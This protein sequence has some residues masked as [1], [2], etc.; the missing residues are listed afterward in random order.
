MSAAQIESL[1]S[2]VAVARGLGADAAA[3]LTGTTLGQ[4]EASADALASVLDEHGVRHEQESTAGPGLFTEIAAAQ[5]RRKQALAE[6]LCGRAPQPRDELGR[7]AKSGTSFDGGARRSVPIAKSPEQAHG[8][9][10][11]QL[12]TASRTFRGTTFSTG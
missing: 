10:L 5:A 6:L 1:R 7:Y 12:I 8:E 9:L 3:F 2:G 11:G 4:I